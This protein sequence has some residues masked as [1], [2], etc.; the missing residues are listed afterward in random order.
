MVDN[1][2]ADVDGDR[3]N[4]QTVYRQILDLLTTAAKTNESLEK[5]FSTPDAA[6]LLTQL[7]TE[8][9]FSVRWPP[10]VDTHDPQY[11]ALTTLY[12]SLK[13]ID[14]SRP[15]VVQL[16]W[17]I[18]IAKGATIDYI[19]RYADLL[20]EDPNGDGS[21]SKLP[22]SRREREIIASSSRS[23]SPSTEDIV[24]EKM[25]AEAV[26][27]AI[28]RAAR[29]YPHCVVCQHALRAVTEGYVDHRIY[30]KVQYHP[31]LLDVLIDIC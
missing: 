24:A 17:L 29:M 11:E 8:I 2:I 30:R 26:G 10:Y 25:V 13:R 19:R 9:A 23:V 28:A 20:R 1:P 15:P 3:L 21:R 27:I 14:T 4:H 12:S 16:A 31:H 6:V 5:I 22:R 7:V 18:T